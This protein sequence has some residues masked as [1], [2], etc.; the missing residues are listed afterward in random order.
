MK[1]LNVL[2]RVERRER[3][4][5]PALAHVAPRAD[6]VGPDIHAHGLQYLRRVVLVWQDRG[7][8]GRDHQ[9]GIRAIDAVHDLYPAGWAAERI[10]RPIAGKPDVDAVRSQGHG[11]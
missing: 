7:D 2:S 3:A 6:D 1:D 10:A 9:R 4:L 5:E 8:G 11:A